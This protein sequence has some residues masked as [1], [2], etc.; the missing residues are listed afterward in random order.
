M[1]RTIMVP[2]FGD[3]GSWW[4]AYTIPERGEPGYKTPAQR[5]AEADPPDPWARTI[6][7]EQAMAEWLD[8]H[9]INEPEPVRVD[10][11]AEAAAAAEAEAEAG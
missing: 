3:S 5:V 7:R 9:P 4:Q 6:A 1:A 10:P 11:A 8:A 2:D